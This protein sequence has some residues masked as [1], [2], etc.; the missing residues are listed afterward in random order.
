MS[1]NGRWDLIRCLKVNGKMLVEVFETRGLRRIFGAERGKVTR[2]WRNYHSV[3]L[4]Y[5]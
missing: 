2:E 1:T 3:E 5:L 4:R